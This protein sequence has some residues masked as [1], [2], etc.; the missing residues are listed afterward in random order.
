MTGSTGHPFIHALD[1]LRRRAVC[2]DLD[3]VRMPSGGPAGLKLRAGAGNASLQ[4]MFRRRPLAI[5]NTSDFSV[6]EPPPAGD[7]KGG[8]RS[9]WPLIGLA[10]IAAL[11]LGA[12]AVARPRRLARAR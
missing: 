10:A 11:A 4:V 9:P 3:D 12:L 8:S 1:T 7:S 6:S 5:V 2:I